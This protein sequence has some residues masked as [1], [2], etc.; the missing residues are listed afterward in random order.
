V[1]SGAYFRPWGPDAC[2]GPRV[3]SYLPTVVWLRYDAGNVLAR[4][5]GLPG[6]DINQSVACPHKALLNLSHFLPRPV[7]SPRTQQQEESAAEIR[8]VEEAAV[9]RESRNADAADERIAL[10]E[11]QVRSCLCGRVWIRQRVCV[12][13]GTL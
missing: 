10:L 5:C 13:V 3:L 12:E 9:A 1:L 7:F 4:P 11:A 2:H 8:K 6:K